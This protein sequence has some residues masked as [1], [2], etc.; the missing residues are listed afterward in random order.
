MGCTLRLIHTLDD[1]ESW[2]TTPKCSW[3]G[4]GSLCVCSV[5]AIWNFIVRIW[6][7]R[8]GSSPTNR[9]N[10]RE[11]SCRSWSIYMCCPPTHNTCSCP[12]RMPFVFFVQLFVLT[13]KWNQVNETFEKII[14]KQTCKSMDNIQSTKWNRNRFE[15]WLIGLYKIHIDTH[16]HTMKY[17]KRETAW[18]I[19]T[20]NHNEK[21]INTMPVFYIT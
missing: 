4:A 6:A 3:S 19:A 5:C 1:S 12:H 16:T 20:K 21:S 17:S 2:S 7:P 14:S 10:P 11:M 8:C 13:E 9:H 15:F 18:E